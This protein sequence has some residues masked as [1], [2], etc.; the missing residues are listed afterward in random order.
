[1]VLISRLLLNIVFDNDLSIA[2]CHGNDGF[3][4][5][6]NVLGYYKIKILTPTAQ[7][8]SRLAKFAL[9]VIATNMLPKKMPLSAR[10]D[11]SMNENYI[12]ELQYYLVTVDII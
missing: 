11:R 1:M 3:W 12:N 2:V 6:T 5:V 7:F 10:H 9:R 8:G 4:C